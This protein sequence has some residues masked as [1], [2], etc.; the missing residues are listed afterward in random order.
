HRTGGV[1]RHEAP[2][3]LRGEY[4]SLHRDQRAHRVTG[5]IERV[6]AEL[7]RALE[8]VLRV[9]HPAVGAES[10]RRART[11]AAEVEGDDLP[12]TAGERRSEYVEAPRV[13]V[14]PR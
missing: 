14:Q 1:D 10:T 12:S 3:A 7:G 2:D 4:R 9:L 6:D 13:R 11:P 8:H 5:E